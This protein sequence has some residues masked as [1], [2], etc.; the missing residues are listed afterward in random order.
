M[1]DLELCRVC[2]DV[3][4]WP[5]DACQLHAQ[6]MM[7]AGMAAAILKG[8]DFFADLLEAQRMMRE[9]GAEPQRM[10][11]HPATYKLI[12]SE[13]LTGPRRMRTMLGG[14]L[15]SSGGI[16]LGGLRVNDIP[17]VQ[18]HDARPGTITLIGDRAPNIVSTLV[19]GED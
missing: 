9:G 6:Q 7:E 14:G 17:V 12:E 19:F 1:K 10:V 13:L 18:Q 11:V 8:G 15:V 5:G 3:A 2:G 16:G 4:I